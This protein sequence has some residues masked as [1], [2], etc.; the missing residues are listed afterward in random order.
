M[1]SVITPELAALFKPLRLYVSSLQCKVDTDEFDSDEPYVIVFVA[2]L[3]NQVINFPGG[4][5]VIPATRTTLI[6]P[7]ND[8]DPDEL[9]KTFPSWDLPP[10]FPPEA[11]PAFF[12]VIGWPCWG[13]DGN[14]FPIPGPS[15]V[16]FLAA[17]VEND[18]GEPNS[19]RTAVQALL[20]T[21]LQNYVNDASLNRAELVQKLI[22]D[23]NGV[24][25][26]AG[27]GFPE[28]DDRIGSAQE[29][30]FTT[31]EMVAARANKASKKLEFKGDGGKYVVTFV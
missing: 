25:D 28:S 16:I 1:S 18:D 6:G 24:I 14:P 11:A 15:T 7:W 17:L 5:I 29:I 20:S 13:T 3:I 21:N 23:M 19:V 4:Q 27:I 9:G 26:F 12:G 2:N 30:G 8:F 31:A 22:N 10:G